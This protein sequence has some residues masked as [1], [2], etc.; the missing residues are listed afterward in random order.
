MP[1]TISGNQNI[2]DK[3]AYAAQD[4]D[5]DEKVVYSEAKSKIEEESV[6]TQ[7]KNSQFEIVQNEIA[8]T[9]GNKTHPSVNQAVAKYLNGTSLAQILESKITTMFDTIEYQKATVVSNESVSGYQEE[10]NEG[11]DASGEKIS[12]HTT[13]YSQALTQEV[14]KKISAQVSEIADAAK[15]DFEK[16][17]NTAIKQT[18][19]ELI[20]GK[21]QDTYANTEEEKN[22][23]FNGAVHTYTSAS[24]GKKDV[25]SAGY[26][27]TYATLVDK[28]GFKVKI[29]N[30][31]GQDL[32]VISYKE[33]GET[34][35][36]IIDD[37]GNIHDLNETKSSI[38]RKNSYLTDES[39]SAMRDVTGNED[40]KAK[41]IKILKRKTTDADSGTTKKGSVAITKDNDRQKH[42]YSV[43][44]D[45]PS[46]G[47]IDNSVSVNEAVVTKDGAFRKKQFVSGDS[48]GTIM[49]NGGKAV[50][51]NGHRTIQYNNENII[52]DN[53]STNRNSSIQTTATNIT[54]R[55]NKEATIQN[56]TRAL[57]DLGYSLLITEDGSNNVSITKQTNTGIEIISSGINLEEAQEFLNNATSDKNRA[58]NAAANNGT[59]TYDAE[60]V[61]IRV[62]IPAD[63]QG[64]WTTTTFE[65]EGNVKIS[66]KAKNVHFKRSEWNH[67]W[68][69]NNQTLLNNFKNNAHS[70]EDVFNLLLANYNLNPADYDFSK[71]RD[72]LISNN[73]SIF[74]NNGH[75][76][77]GASFAKRLDLP[78]QEVIE[79][80]CK[81]PDVTT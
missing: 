59:A 72:M 80:L 71:I 75:V 11:T 7:T 42:Y 36:V 5:T 13:G 16:K 23:E 65:G 51:Q 1:N 44:N 77:K 62:A 47:Y 28:K 60:K 20:K 31:D 38:F 8:S 17:L 73:P 81:R 52:I 6:F 35:H 27:A 76:Y 33:G 3:F 2:P 41:D 32:K 61:D 64:G 25:G 53:K 21:Q 78:T 19:S 9:F 46:G 63:S 50:K 56:L 54:Q 45:A 70:A 40:L 34:K 10:G 26:E 57:N 37:E 29:R 4:K 14:A 30:V 66:P 39:L 55:L 22:S 18:Q 79:R 15:K 74:D 12:K 24:Q 49:R 69:K 48:V 68:S 58:D 67:N 43:T